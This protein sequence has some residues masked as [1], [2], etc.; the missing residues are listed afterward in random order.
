MQLRTT[1]LKVTS[2]DIYT[3]SL[4]YSSLSD[5]Q[6]SSP[7]KVRVPR[8]K[9]FVWKFLPPLFLFFAL[10]VQLIIRVEILKVGYDLASLKNNALEGDSSLREL[11]MQF[12]VVSRPEVLERQALKIGLKQI[13]PQQVRVLSQ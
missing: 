4:Q 1:Q 7:R 2:E 13:H 6:I 10:L 12:A 5:Q 3:S 11:K 9:E 8:R